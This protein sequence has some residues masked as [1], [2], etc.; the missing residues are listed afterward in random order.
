MSTITAL[1]DVVAFY[2]AAHLAVLALFAVA[3]SD[4]VVTER[5][6]LFWKVLALTVIAQAALAVWQAVT[7]STAPAGALFNGWA[8]EFSVR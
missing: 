6:A 5:A 2:V 4:L 7:Q 3:A 1:D 8:R